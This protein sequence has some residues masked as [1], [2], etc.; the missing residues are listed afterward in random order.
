MSVKRKEDYLTMVSKLELNY[1]T[2][3]EK[4]MHQTHNCCF[5]KYEADIE[6]RIEVEKQR[7]KSHQQGM[8]LVNEMNR[9]VHR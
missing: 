1:T 2:E 6:K 4:A 9:Q 7:E 8:Y 5:A 3:M